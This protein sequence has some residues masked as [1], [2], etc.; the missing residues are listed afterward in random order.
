MKGTL[1]HVDFVRVRADQTIQAEVALNLLGEPE[2]VRRAACSSSS[3]TR[4]PSRAC[5]GQLPTAIEHDVTALVI[6]DQ[7]HVGDLTLP[8][9][10]LVTN[11][12][13]DAHRA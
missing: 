12:A 3:C 11:D 7:L 4:S 6:G 1:V 8:A 13:D 2:G 5:P 10:V 9:G